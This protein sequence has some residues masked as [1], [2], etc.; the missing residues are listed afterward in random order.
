MSPSEVHKQELLA[1][2]KQFLEVLATYKDL[3]LSD[4]H[5]T[6]FIDTAKVFK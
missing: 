6:I 5:D 4:R 1:A 3:V 2:L